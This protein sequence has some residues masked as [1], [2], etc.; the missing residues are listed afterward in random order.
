MIPGLHGHRYSFIV[1]ATNDNGSGTP[2]VPSMPINKA[3]GPLPLPSA[4]QQLG[5]AAAQGA[6]RLLWYPPK[7]ATCALTDTIWCPNPVLYYLVTVTGGQ[8]YT[9][10]GISQ[11]LTSNHGA[12]ILYVIEGLSSGQEY[13]ISVA[14]VTPAGAGPASSVSQMAG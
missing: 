14:A 4:P 11:V 7:T 6:I 5:G 8:Q 3:T 2:S 9:V 10:S 13:D 12:R 1:A